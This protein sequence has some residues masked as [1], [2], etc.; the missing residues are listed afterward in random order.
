[1]SGSP[2]VRL[3]QSRVA[4]NAAVLYA[5]HIAGLF[6]PLILVPYL[7]RVL[8]PEGWGLVVFAQSFAAWLALVLEYGFYLSATRLIARVRDDPRRVAEVVADVQGARVLLVAFLL[9]AGALSYVAVPIF[10][11]NP[12]YLVFAWL[13]AVAQGLNPSWYFQGVERMQLPAVLEIAG[14]AAATVGVFVLVK[15]PQDGWAVLALQAGGG[16]AWVAVSSWMIYREVPFIRPTL[17]GAREML[18]S[19]AGLFV[20]R[21]ATGMYLQANSFILGLVSTAQ[22]VAF[23]GGAEKI[24]RAAIGLIQ[25]VTQAL[26]PRISHLA[27]SDHRRA[28]ALVRLSL[29]LVGGL[30]ILLGL[31]ALAAAPVLVRLILGPGYEA[32]IPVLRVLALLPPLIAVGT[33]LGIQ[34]ALPVGLDRP[35]YSFVIAAGLLNVGMAVLL[36]PR[37]GALGMAIS[38]VLA[39][40]VV[41]SGLLWLAVRQGDGL[42]RRRGF[43]SVRRMFADASES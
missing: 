36:A 34:W 37:L 35:F 11:S 39:D 21:S 4:Q 42:L 32:A 2:F 5:V 20:F 1:M 22:A 40:L 27:A 26:Y 14:K 43:R 30:G 23:F 6:L 3:R 8:R 28:H 25:P 12:E 33:V 19:S 15:G 24:I 31:V 10:R 9:V 29:L 18:R 17:R 38:V 13:F 41:A 16:F 7:A